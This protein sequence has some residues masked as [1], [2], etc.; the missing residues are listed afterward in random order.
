MKIKFRK[1]IVIEG[2]VDVPVR[3]EIAKE[4]QI[5]LV[6]ALQEDSFVVKFKRDGEIFYIE[7]PSGLITVSKTGK[8]IYGLPVSDYDTLRELMDLFH[9][10]RESLPDHL[11][12][13]HVKEGED[14]VF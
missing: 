11:P 2:T 12:P 5:L 8:K 3:E 4:V 10:I 13:V 7:I 1:K 6:E 9:T 14:S